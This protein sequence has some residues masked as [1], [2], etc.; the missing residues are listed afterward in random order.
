MEKPSEFDV[1][2]IV[3]TGTSRE[4]PQEFDV[5]K[6]ARVVY[7]KR[8]V[9]I[10]VMM[11]VTGVIA[12]AG[13]LLPDKYEATSTVLIEG[14]FA[15]DAL[16]GVAV[17]ASIDD[18]VRA[19]EII[20]QSRP[21]VLKVLKELGYD[22]GRD[23]EGEVEQLVGSFQRATKI[24]FDTNRSRRD[25]D[26]FS[27]SVRRGNPVIARDYVNALVRSFIAESLSSKRNE[28]VETKKFLVE[29]VD[30]LRKTI[31]TLD[32][33]IANIH[34]IS[35]IEAEIAS[36]HK[37]RET[38]AVGMKPAKEDDTQTR[39]I[40]IRKRLG[41]LLLQYTLKH[42]EV[43]KIQ[44]E[45]AYLERQE[46]EQ[47]QTGRGREA[48][49]VAPAVKARRT[50]GVSPA[51]AGREQRLNE[52]ERD[53]NS[54]QKMYEEMLV[55]LGKSEVSSRL[56]GQDKGVTFNVL[57]PA[58]LPLRPVSPNRVLIIVLG[59]FA[60]I[61]AAIVSVIRMDSMDKSVKS[62][63]TVKMFGHPVLAVFP[64]IQLPR[65]TDWEQVMNLLLFIVTLLYVE[66]IAVLLMVVSRD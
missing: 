20:M 55:T 24:T 32:D 61:G 46:H 54:Y 60:G 28:T 12:A 51:M 41:D 52:L 30:I 22:L 6:Y 38:D 4:R 66:G 39:L 57:E 31:G 36:I 3:R 27:V 2:K 50:G 5:K 49:T 17:P 44:E 23:T 8:Y 15:N 19:V 7:K 58:I 9:F 26:M 21:Q 13:C 1:V 42:P 43:E 63:D 47:K 62:L 10:T 11:L 35:A 16:K 53:R 14:N 25:V 37:K 18:R 34:Q 64:H 45:L 56:E 33:E 48:A 40:A 65:E 59:F 29:Q